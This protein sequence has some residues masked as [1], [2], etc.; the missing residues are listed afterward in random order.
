[1]SGFRSAGTITPARDRSFVFG[2]RSSPRLISSSTPGFASDFPSS[3]TSTIST[4]SP[5]TPSTNGSVSGDL[6]AVGAQVRQRPAEGLAF[7]PVQRPKDA[8]TTEVIN[9]IFAKA[10]EQH[11]RIDPKRTIFVGPGRW[12]SIAELPALRLPDG[13]E[14]LIVTVH[15]YDPFYFTHRGRPGPVP[16]TKLTGIIFPV[17]RLSRWSRAHR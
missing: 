3:S 17:H 12:N 14:N 16:S 4:S 9:P 13:D 6:A 15:N 11:R 2:L 8:A 10:I 7:E 1:M 5:P